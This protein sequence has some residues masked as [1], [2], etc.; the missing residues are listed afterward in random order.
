MPESFSGGLLANR[1]LENADHLYV[2][3]IRGPESFAIWQGRVF[4]GL[5]DGRIAEVLPSSLKTVAFI[6]PNNVGLEQCRKAWTA[7]SGNC[8]RP[9]GLRFD[10]KGSLYTVDP[11]H[12]IYKVDIATGKY[13]LILDIQK[14]RLPDGTVA[15]FLDDLVLAEK[16]NGHLVFYLTLA[17]TR[18]ALQ[19]C[20]YTVGEFDQTGQL[21]SFDTE[22]GRFT[23]EAT[24]LA[25]PNGLEW[26]A[27]KSAILVNELSTRT[28]HKYHLK[29]ANKGQLT[30]W[31]NNLPGE[32]DNIKRSGDPKRETYLVGL[33]MG[34][35]KHNPSLFDKVTE[36]ALLRRFHFR[37]QRAIGFVIQTIGEISEC[38]Y[39][40]SLGYEI[41]VGNL[42]SDHS[43]K[44]Y[45]L[46]IEV[47]ANGNIINSFHDP[48]G[49]SSGFSELHEVRHTE[50]ERHFLLGSFQGHYLG[51]LVVKKCQLNNVDDHKVNS[52]GGGGDKPATRKVVVEEEKLKSS[53]GTSTPSTKPTEKA[54]PN[55]A[56]EKVGKHTE[57]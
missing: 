55:E 35:N 40:T 34:R 7:P 45:G 12:G 15:G 48:S 6:D 21:L 49:R 44:H 31:V 17:S 24:G 29:G 25:F 10:S 30:V 51:R 46:V 56:K 11:Y 1:L 2:N 9:L 41:R 42:M 27:D 20:F 19:D 16:G 43:A 5:A 26:T 3:E 47:D 57:L 4:T 50:T 54:K 32:P 38:D 53:S 36:H 39:L 14:H 52:G 22:T 18:W 8:S 33:F 23:V 28:I 13:E 37:A